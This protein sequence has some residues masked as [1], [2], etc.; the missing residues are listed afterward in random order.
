MSGRRR[1]C[2]SPARLWS[3][4]APRGT[5]FLLS[6][7]GGQYLLLATLVLVPGTLLFA[8]A[9]RRNGERVFTPWEV[10]VF[11][12]AGAAAIATAVLLALGT[13]TV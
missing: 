1:H 10:V 13:I 9:R 7:A 4:S 2:A 6:A 5:I 8:L 12:V 11:A 3:P